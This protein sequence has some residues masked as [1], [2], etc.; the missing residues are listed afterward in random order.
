MSKKIVLF[1]FILMACFLI[2]CIAMADTTPVSKSKD[3][4]SIAKPTIVSI[5]PA[6]GKAGEKTDFTLTGTGFT[7]GLK[8]FLEKDIGGKKDMIYAD[9]VKIQSGTKLTG[10]FAI[11]SQ[12][13]TGVWNLGLEF[14]DM[15]GTSKITFNVTT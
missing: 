12:A 2:S 5:T 15:K 13:P 4:S 6:S 9:S 8:V 7:D 14:N 11:V 10:T 1:T 3:T